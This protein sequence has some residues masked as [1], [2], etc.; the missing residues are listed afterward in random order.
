MREEP[1]SMG[2]SN[3]AVRCSAWV[4]RRMTNF[5]SRKGRRTLIVQ[6]KRKGTWWGQGAGIQCKAGMHTNGNKP[7]PRETRVTHFGGTSPFR[8]V[9]TKG[10]GRAVHVSCSFRAPQTTAT[11]A[12]IHRSRELGWDHGQDSRL[13]LIAGPYWPNEDPLPSRVVWY[14]LTR[15]H[16]WYQGS[17]RADSDSSKDQQTRGTADEAVDASN[18]V[19]QNNAGPKE[20]QSGWARL[21]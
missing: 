5:G 16:R 8:S 10:A 3:G 9:S 15:L 6:A 11:P 20:K 13:I 1:L 21:Q 12:M 4:Q 18:L 2:N 17:E 7:L 14:M 19:T